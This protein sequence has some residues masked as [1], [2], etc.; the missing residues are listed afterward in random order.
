MLRSEGREVQLLIWTGQELSLEHEE[1]L[2]RKNFKTWELNIRSQMMVTGMTVMFRVLQ[3]CETTQRAVLQRTI[4]REWKR[5]HPFWFLLTVQV[6]EERHRQ[7]LLKDNR[8]FFKQLEAGFWVSAVD[9]LALEEVRCRDEI[10]R[11]RID[12][13]M[14]WKWDQTVLRLSHA[15]R[16]GRNAIALQFVLISQ[17]MLQPFRMLR[18]Y[19]SLESLVLD[20]LDK[21]ADMRVSEA[22]NRRLILFDALQKL[23]F[24]R[25][26]HIIVEEKTD[27]QAL[28]KELLTMTQVMMIDH[29]ARLHLQKR[30]VGVFAVM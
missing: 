23:Q 22:L 7:G 9:V 26:S 15:E 1:Y 28:I 2:A 29:S 5:M 25:R 16:F 10:E 6:L 21:G 14:S 3:W 27:F 19:Y 11:S 8:I 30:Q 18:S 17:A 13:C 12:L 20:S 24:V 4:C